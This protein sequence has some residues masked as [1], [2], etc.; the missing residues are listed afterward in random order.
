M[1][2][3]SGGVAAGIALTGAAHFR[4]GLSYESLADTGINPIPES[5]R[6]LALTIAVVNPMAMW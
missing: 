1:T 3:L 5:S 4:I 6:L 2:R